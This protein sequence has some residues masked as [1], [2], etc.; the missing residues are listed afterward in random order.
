MGR[1]DTAS[2]LIDAP[3]DRVFAALIDPEALAVWL[4]PPE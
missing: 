2:R 1:T 3:I 4:P